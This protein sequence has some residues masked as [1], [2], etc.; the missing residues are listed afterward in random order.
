MLDTLIGWYISLALS[1]IVP[2]FGKF[3]EQTKD[4][5]SHDN[6]LSLLMKKLHS[7]HHSNC[8][9]NTDTTIPKDD[10]QSDNAKSTRRF[11]QKIRDREYPSEY[12]EEKE[13]KFIFYLKDIDNYF[14]LI[15]K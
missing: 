2:K 13:D 15:A 1:K 4:L 6:E 14:K 10:D 7:L 11:F 9:K 12:V 5:S 3:K 8:H